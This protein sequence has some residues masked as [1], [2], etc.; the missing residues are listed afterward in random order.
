MGC[1]VSLPF[2][3]NVYHE[4][5][6]LYYQQVQVILYLAGI[7]QC[8]LRLNYYQEDEQFFHLFRTELC[9]RFKRVNIK[10]KVAG[11]GTFLTWL[12]YCVVNAYEKH[13]F[14]LYLTLHRI[15]S[16]SIC[17]QTRFSEFKT[18]VFKQC[19]H[20]KFLSVSPALAKSVSFCID[21]FRLPY[22]H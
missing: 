20:Y 16:R 1:S 21:R 9:R 22:I 11:D 12:S 3:I 17:S 8:H 2:S 7:P 19:L 5:V 15:L 13:F 18:S 4:S 6:C 10:E 14:C